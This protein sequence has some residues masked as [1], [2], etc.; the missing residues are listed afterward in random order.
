MGALGLAERVDQLPEIQERDDLEGQQDHV[1]HRGQEIGRQL[2]L[3]QFVDV[4]HGQEASRRTS[5]SVSRVT[6]WMNRSSRELRRRSSRRSGQP[7]DGQLLADR[8]A[9]VAAVARLHPEAGVGAVLGLRDDAIDP[10]HD[11]DRAADR[12]GRAAGLDHDRDLAPQVIQPLV[13]RD[14]APG[15][16]DHPIADRLDL[17]QDVGRQQD[18]VAGAQL[19]DQRPDLQDLDRVQARRRLVEDQDRRVVQQRLGQADPLAEPPRELPDDPVLDLLQPAPGDDLGHRAPHVRP[20]HVLEPGPEP[21]ELPHPHL[22]VERDALRQVAELA[23]HLQ[24]LVE[25]VVSRQGRPAARRGQE[26]REHP[27]R[28]RLPGPVGAQEPDDLAAAHREAHVVD[29]LE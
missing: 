15:D 21:Q 13:H 11:L 19:A 23:P 27:H 20:R 4:S 22:G 16:D 3:Q 17:R 2:A 28:R 5:A 26:R 29:R 1:G 7:P 10:R 9:E 24:R 8:L 6:A 25:H 12:V 18:R 14:P